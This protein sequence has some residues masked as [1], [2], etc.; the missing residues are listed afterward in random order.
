LLPTFAQSADQE[1]HNSNQD[2]ANDRRYEK[3]GVSGH[4]ASSDPRQGV[5]PLLAWWRETIALIPPHR[6]PTLGQVTPVTAPE[7]CWRDPV[8]APARRWRRHSGHRLPRGACAIGPEG[9][10]L[11]VILAVPLAV[12]EMMGNVSGEEFLAV[13][14]AGAEVTARLAVAAATPEAGA[15]PPKVL[16]GQL[17]GCISA[18]GLALMQASETMQL[19]VDGDPPA[20]AIYA[21]FPNLVGVLSVL[22][23]RQGLR[24]ECEAFEG[25]AGLFAMHYAGRYA[26][27]VLE[28]RLG[29]SVELLKVQFKPWPTTAVAHVFI[30]TALQVTATHDVEATAIDRV[31]VRGEK[32]IQPCRRKRT[33]PACLPPRS[34]RGP[35][36]SCKGARPRDLLDAAGHCSVEAENPAS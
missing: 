25:T 6:K 5:S 7:A 13:L 22:L 2:T 31:T 28:S 30:D 14:A 20:K 35:A 33:F 18:L 9:A 19:V 10:H 36:R 12:V 21:A 17:L 23:S 24:A 29:E 27:E 16:E 3:D 8:E 1:N 4:P 32:S 15:G 26:S 11:V 34:T